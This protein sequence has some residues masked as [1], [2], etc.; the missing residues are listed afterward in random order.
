MTSAGDNRLWKI[1]SSSWAIHNKWCKVRQDVVELPSG[2]V[3]DDYFVTVT[4]GIIFVFAVTIDGKVAL[5][6]EYQ[7]GVQAMSVKFPAGTLDK[8][9]EDI[10]VAAKREL[11]EE[12]GCSGG[13]WESLGSWQFD[14]GKSTAMTHV[15]LAKNV[16]PGSQVAFDITE[17]IEVEFCPLEE[18]RTK[19]KS[20][21]INVLPCA[22]VGYIA[23]DRLKCF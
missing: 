19:L 8:E 7:H 16:I 18:I 12:T 11:L 2:A 22:A 10:L 9:G 5:V 23:L 21:Y 14:P 20:G 4:T 3:V 15:F 13:E 6:H 1:L 17:E